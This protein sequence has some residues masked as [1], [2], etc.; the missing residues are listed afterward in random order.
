[1][2]S[3]A[4]AI[5][6]V[7]LAIATCASEAQELVQASRADEAQTPLRVYAPEQS[8]CAPL[9][10]ISP[11]AGGS[12]DGYKYLATG[13]REDGWRAIVVGHKESGMAALRSDMRE[14]RGLRK[15]LQELVNDPKAYEAR[16]MDIGAALKWANSTCKA[17]FVA[18]LGHSMGARTVEVEAGAKN[19]FGLKSQNRFDAY[20]ALS[21]DGPGKMFPENAWS[22]I[23]KPILLLTGTKD[24]SLDGDWRTRTVPYDSLPAGCKWLGVIE[25]ATHM[26][27]AGGGLAGATE[28]LTLLETKAFLDSLRNGKCGA[29][30]SQDGITLKNK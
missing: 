24:S 13:L 21:P 28:K 14:S 15:G 6:T 4:L 3:R 11:G 10:L 25:G 5:A 27:F 23:R 9:A 19:N 26:N 22:E 30:V 17:P 16:F 8:G 20:V 18:L 29:S 1:M 12:E 2:K 7:V